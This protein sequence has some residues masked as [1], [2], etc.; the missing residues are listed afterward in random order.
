MRRIAARRVIATVAHLITVRDGADGDL[1]GD[2]MRT[3][4]AVLPIAVQ[5]PVLPRPTCVRPA[6]RINEVPERLGIGLGIEHP[7][8]L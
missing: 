3:T 6:A 8:E 2:T 4:V 5:R 1:V 7:I